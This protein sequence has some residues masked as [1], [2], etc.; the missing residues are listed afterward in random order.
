MTEHSV[1]DANCW[2]AYVDEAASG[3][4]G[5]ATDTYK[6]AQTLGA[7]LLDEGQLIRQ[8]YL[9]VRQGFGEAWF[10]AFFE[11]G[12]VRGK[13]KLVS[14]SG[15]RDFVKSLKGLGV[16]A[17]EFIYFKVAIS[18]GATYIISEDIDFFEPSLKKAGHKAEA[19][20]TMVKMRAT[21]CVCRY[22]KNGHGIQIKCMDAFLAN[23]E[24]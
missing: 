21:G 2:S 6:R 17:S 1:I 23:D 7:V 4:P 11:D 8:Q 5:R 16:P 20:R 10:N 18:G 22:F 12:V 15:N 9:N 19:K 3:N 14:A 24:E 13:V